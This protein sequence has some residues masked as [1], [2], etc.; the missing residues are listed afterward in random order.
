MR[1]VQSVSEKGATKMKTL[2]VE[3]NKEISE[4]LTKF[5]RLSGF[6]CDT[7]FNGKEG[8]KQILANNYDF[9]L[10]DIAMPGYSGIDLIDSLEKKGKLKTQKIIILTASSLTDEELI[11][12]LKRGVHHCLRKPIDLERLLEVITSSTQS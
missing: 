9:V 12:L 5:L 3:D 11:A 2:L 8:V 10:L 6:D 4:M 1:Y 7:A